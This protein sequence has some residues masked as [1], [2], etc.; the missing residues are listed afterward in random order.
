VGERP[1]CAGGAGEVTVSKVT[2]RAVIDHLKERVEAYENEDWTVWDWSEVAD[3]L[4]ALVEMGRD[5]Q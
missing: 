3:E 5:E 4:L 1:A 2:R